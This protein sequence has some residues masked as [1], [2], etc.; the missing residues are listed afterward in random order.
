MEH[1]KQ[2]EELLRRA[3]ECELIANLAT[4][5]ENKKTYRNMAELYRRLAKRAPAF[6]LFAKSKNGRSPGGR[7]ST[8]IA[9]I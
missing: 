7:T 2:A 4:T 9:A 8:T 3:D 1:A 6:R 5:D